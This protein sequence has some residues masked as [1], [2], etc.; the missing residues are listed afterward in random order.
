MRKWTYRLHFLNDQVGKFSEDGLKH[1]TFSPISKDW[2]SKE[3]TIKQT[4]FY[5]MKDPPGGKGSQRG[6]DGIRNN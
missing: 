5:I 2:R 4:I 6:A 1:S 3:K